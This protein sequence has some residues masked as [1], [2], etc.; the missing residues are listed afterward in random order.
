MNKNEIIAQAEKEGIKLSEYTLNRYI[1][2]GLIPSQIHSNGYK[3]SVQA[4]YPD[5]MANIRIIHQTRQDP[6]LGHQKHLLPYLFWNGYNVRTDDLQ[7]Y[8]LKYQTHVQKAFQQIQSKYEDELDIEWF[9][10]LLNQD[11]DVRTARPPGRPSVEQQA[12]RKSQDQAMRAFNQLL[13][14]WIQQIA[15]GQR[16]AAQEVIE[17]FIPLEVRETH[18]MDMILFL[19]Q[20]FMNGFH[21]LQ[22]E[23]L[24]DW[25]QLNDLATAMRSY[26]DEFELIMSALLSP[27]VINIPEQLKTHP[28][29]A[30]LILLFLLTSH[31]AYLLQNLISADPFRT[32][33]QQIIELLKGGKDNAS[34]SVID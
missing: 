5:A 15:A 3:R 33:I 23:E 26:S 32:V 6:R 29:V 13:I 7:V 34:G 10:D 14:R 21:W 2:F 8:M 4:D 24:I 25:S 19:L 16:I 9:L 22:P 28:R 30:P 11:K 20:R 12:E 1:S 31:Q 27:T 17:A 18:D